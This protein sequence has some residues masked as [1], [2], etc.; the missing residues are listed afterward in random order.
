MKKQQATA[1]ENK[2]GIAEQNV[3]KIREII[4]G[5]Q[6]RD[7]EQRF[8][9]LEKRVSVTHEA[10]SKDITSRIQKLEGFIRKEFEKMSELWARE[11]S[12]LKQEDEENRAYVEDLEKELEGRFVDLD[13]QL[14]VGSEALRKSIETASAE[15]MDLIRENR[16]QLST[17]IDQQGRT[18]DSSKV[19]RDDLA[20]MLAEVAKRLQAD[21]KA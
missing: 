8:A 20:A 18:L 10:L 1:G 17:I 12:A 6:M 19:A 5:G 13:E 16:E 7:Y 21:G 15:L 9:E 11:H 2:Q 3:D 14:A 4:F